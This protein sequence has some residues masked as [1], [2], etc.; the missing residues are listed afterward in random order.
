MEEMLI[1]RSFPVKRILFPANLFFFKPF[2]FSAHTK[3]SPM[4]P[5]PHRSLE[6]CA[7]QKPEKVAHVA[8]TCIFCCLPITQSG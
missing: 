5:L 3:G 8:A 1:S 2:V 6:R 7:L 4:L